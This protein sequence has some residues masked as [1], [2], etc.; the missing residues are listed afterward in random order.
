MPA[1]RRRALQACSGCKSPGLS[2]R[3]S[4]CWAPALWHMP[5]MC[6]WPTTRRLPAVA[7]ICAAYAAVRTEGIAT[8]AVSVTTAATV[9]VAAVADT[10][11]GGGVITAQPRPSSNGRVAAITANRHTQPR[12]ATASTWPPSADCRRQLAPRRCPVATRRAGV[13]LNGTGCVG[14]LR[15]AGGRLRVRL[16]MPPCSGRP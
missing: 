3:S 11:A 10:V 7:W 14:G 4:S 12:P 15:W 8:M 1:P 2:P 9:L 6:H 5:S 13:A 16:R